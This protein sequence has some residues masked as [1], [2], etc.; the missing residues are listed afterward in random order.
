MRWKRPHA[1]KAR[2]RSSSG[3][4]GPAGFRGLLIS[5]DIIDDIEP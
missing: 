3:S 2:L 4:M 5:Y 1:D